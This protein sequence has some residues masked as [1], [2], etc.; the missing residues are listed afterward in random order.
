MTVSP[1]EEA[2]PGH[3][4]GSIPGQTV[5]TP[6]PYSSDNSDD[7]GAGSNSGPDEKIDY[8]PPWSPT[9]APGTV[10]TIAPGEIIPIDPWQPTIALL[11]GDQLKILNRETAARQAASFYVDSARD[12]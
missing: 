1:P 4:Q 8:L 10:R 5:D 7:Y 6:D 12:I 11:N 3:D 9:R 2:G